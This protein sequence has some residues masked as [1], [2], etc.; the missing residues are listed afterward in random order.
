M[1]LF[2]PGGNPAQIWPG[3]PTNGPETL[4]RNIEQLSRDERVGYRLETSL[5]KPERRHTSREQ[6]YPML[7]KS[8]SEP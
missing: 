4:L 1:I 7:H 5:A 2:L 3:G 6:E 8:A